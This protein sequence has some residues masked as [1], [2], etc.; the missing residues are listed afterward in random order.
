MWPG[1]GTGAGQTETED[2]T[3]KSTQLS[4]LFLSVFC[5]Y[6]QVEVGRG[7]CVCVSAI[8]NGRQMKRRH[9]C[10]LFFL[11]PAAFVSKVSRPASGGY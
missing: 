1:T 6:L 4:N 2:T 10:R 11:T 3:R 7:V 9:I 8:L 5:F